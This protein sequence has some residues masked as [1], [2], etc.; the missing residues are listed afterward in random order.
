MLGEEFPG[1][2][3]I[4]IRRG[5]ALLRPD[6]DPGKSR[7]GG[8]G[9]VGPGFV[10]HRNPAPTWGSGSILAETWEI[11]AGGPEWPVLR[12]GPGPRVDEEQNVVPNP[13]GGRRGGELVR[14]PA[15]G[16]ARP[17]HADLNVRR[18]LPREGRGAPGA[19]RGVQ[20]PGS[21]PVGSPEAGGPAVGLRARPKTCG[22]PWPPRGSRP[23]RCASSEVLPGEY[24]SSPRL[25][26]R[27]P[28]TPKGPHRF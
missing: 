4:R 11:G 27:G 23:R 1:E 16:A 12:E 2:L 9:R 15:L 28:G 17:G 19:P 6:H 14:A 21:H 8:R 25:A 24:A 20:A 22:A 13:V 3:A 26:D 10:F 7:Y 18:V 5:P